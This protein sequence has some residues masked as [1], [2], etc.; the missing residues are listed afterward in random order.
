MLVEPEAETDV[1]AGDAIGSGDRSRAT[2]RGNRV[3]WSGRSVRALGNRPAQRCIRSGRGARGASWSRCSS[4]RRRASARR[5]ARPGSSGS[6]LRSGA[7][8]RAPGSVVARAVTSGG[9]DAASA[10]GPPSRRASPDAGR[11]SPSPPDS[12]TNGIRCRSAASR[13]IRS[14]AVFWDRHLSDVV[15]LF[16]ERHRPAADDPLRLP[17]HQPR[18]VVAVHV[19]PGR[20]EQVVRSLKP[21]LERAERRVAS[22]P[23]ALVDEATGR[24]DQ[25]VAGHPSVAEAGTPVTR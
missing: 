20:L 23:L 15:G 21:D 19:P 16:V 13:L 6:P 9:V 5:S 24:G 10:A 14:A 11:R 7:R 18:E 1:V 25:L 17:D 4:A 22:K 2:D 3:R 12:P 8:S